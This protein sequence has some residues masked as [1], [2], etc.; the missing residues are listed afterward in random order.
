MLSR[1][2]LTTL[3]VSC[4]MQRVQSRALT[5]LHSI[6]S[7]MDADS[8]GGAAGL[9]AASQHLSTLVFGAAGVTC[10][11]LNVS[12]ESAVAKT[13]LLLCRGCDGCRKRMYEDAVQHHTDNV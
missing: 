3:C 6:L 9:Q 4:R 12:V 5:C 10:H 8:L 13:C 2:A 1:C 7:A 11:L